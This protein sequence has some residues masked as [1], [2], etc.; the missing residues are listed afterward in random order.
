MTCY[1]E[2]SIGTCKS[3]DPKGLYARAEAGEIPNFTGISAPFDL[4]QSA[5]LVLKTE[6]FNLETLTAQAISRILS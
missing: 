2:A 4:P 1:V 6:S 5:E 3:R